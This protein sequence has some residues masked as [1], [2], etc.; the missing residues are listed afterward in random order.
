MQAAQY[1]E[2]KLFITVD[3][4]VARLV[5]VHW[6]PVRAAVTSVALILV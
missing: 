6:S 2:R 4:A 1:A 3:V 5:I